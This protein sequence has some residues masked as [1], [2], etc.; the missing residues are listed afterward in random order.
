MEL[1]EKYAHKVYEL[2][3]FSSAARALFVSQPALS[4]MVMRLEAS[5]G[6]KIFDR[7]TSPLSLTPEGRIYMEYLD[8]SIEREVEMTRRVRNLSQATDGSISVGGSCYT[9]YRLLSEICG[10][11]Y[12][13][14]PKVRVNLDMGNE[15][16][17]GNLQDKLLSGTLDL[18]LGYDYD[19][20]D[21]EGR[22]ILRERLGIAMH[23]NLLTDAMRPYALTRVEFLNSKKREERAFFDSAIFNGTPFLRLGR[24]TSTEK[25][26]KEILGETQISHYNIENAHHTA[27]HYNIM[28]KGLG[29]VMIADVH[30]ATSNLLD[31]EI[32]YFIPKSEASFRPLY[33]IS[34]AGV[35]PGAVSRAFVKISERVAEGIYDSGSITEA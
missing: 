29:A 8:E 11:F 10:E 19:P 26:M 1:S 13:E 18:M 23:K 32:V 20:N 16:S 15:A 14:Y 31:P 24:H 12:K 2:R 22:V 35:V 21:F 28:R 7:S 30:V 5:L 3:S 4:A 33:L 17:L 34:R 25:K 27:M 9:A 6:F